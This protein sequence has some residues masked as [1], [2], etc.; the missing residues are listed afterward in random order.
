[1]PNVTEHVT[2]SM[3]ICSPSGYQAQQGLLGVR[4]VIHNVLMQTQ[5][6]GG[7]SS[8]EPH[9]G[10]QLPRFQAYKISTSLCIIRQKMLT[11]IREQNIGKLILNTTVRFFCSP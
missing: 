2:R 7:V 1:M 8:V 5:G 10:L 4:S 3:W 9:R 11:S 6:G